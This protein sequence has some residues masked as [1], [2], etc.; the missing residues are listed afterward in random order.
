MRLAGGAFTLIDESY[1]A[2][3]VSIARG[4]AHAWACAPATGRRIAV[5]TDMLELGARSARATTPAWPAEIE[6][7]KVDLVFCAG[8]MMKCLC[9]TRFRRLAKAAYA[10][11]AAEL[12]P[13]LVRAV[14]PG[15][16]VMVKGSQRIRRPRRL[17]E[18]LAAARRPASG[19]AA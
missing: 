15:D 11:T 2:N 1:N 7:A 12:A 18:A 9:A 17:S 5:L 13:P 4:A 19:E 6:A 3:P 8:P 10:E 14:E 16:V